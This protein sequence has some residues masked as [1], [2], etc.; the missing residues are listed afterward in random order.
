MECWKPLR[1]AVAQ[2]IGFFGHH[3][4]QQR[5]FRGDVISSTRLYLAPCMGA[6]RGASSKRLVAT[7]DVACPRGTRLGWTSTHLQA[8]A[9]TGGG[10]GR[11]VLGAT[12]RLPIARVV[13]G[14]AFS[15]TREGDGRRGRIERMSRSRHPRV[16]PNAA[17]DAR[18]LRARTC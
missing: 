2:R 8:V 6:E 14:W 15:T 12:V 1:S 9:Q 3:C 11:P 4:S 18:W 7:A 17:R 16:P 5:L 10:R 13:L